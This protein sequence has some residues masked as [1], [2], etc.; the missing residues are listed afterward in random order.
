MVELRADE[1]GVAL[2][3]PSLAVLIILVTVFV[4]VVVRLVMG[5]VAVFVA[6]G[7]TLLMG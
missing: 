2:A 5:G 3:L 6:A 7:V 1:E 4:T